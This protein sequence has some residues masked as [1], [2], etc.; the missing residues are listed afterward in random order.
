M[1]EATDHLSEQPP[2]AQ[3]LR[4]RVGVLVVLAVAAGLILWLVLRDSGGSSSEPTNATT[5]SESQLS[6]LAASVNHPVFWIGPRSG[7]TYE[8]TQS[9]NGNILIRYLPAGVQPGSKDP[10]L[11][12]ATYPFAG[13][14]AALQT[15]STQGGSI[16][17]RLPNGGLGVI[18]RTYPESVH[19]AYPNVDYQVE[20]FDPSP[21]KAIDAARRLAA[22]GNVT[23]G[24]GAAPA[25][26]SPAGLKSLAG[27]LGHPVYWIGPKPG[28]TYE[29][30]RTA[31]G[32]VYIRYLPPGVDVG[33][34]EPYLSVATYPFPGA[35][36]ALQALPKQKNAA[37]VKLP[38][39]GLALIDKRY[40][41]S[42]HVAFPNSDYQIEV[43][44]P[45]PDAVRKIVSA[46]RVKPIG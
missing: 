3:S 10:Y 30:T 24:S 35:L 38:G 5:V 17:I 33:A 40:P 16:S 20:V 6:A 44:D 41:K 42:I 23:K 13:A 4:L 18:S 36:A 34:A 28:H 14:Y 25:A 7:S 32:S 37:V 12:V 43:F 26:V 21:S 27:Q 8:L 46:G 1:T 39:G 22:L 2:R 19:V 11:T 29:V 15:L 31:N 45:S 9:S